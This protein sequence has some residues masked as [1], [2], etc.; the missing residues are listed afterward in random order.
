MNWVLDGITVLLIMIFAATSFNRG[1]LNSVV[2][3]LGTL[4][5]ISASV[6]VSQPAAEFIFDN[7]LY[8][9]INSVVTKHMG[10]ISEFDIAAFTDGMSDLIKELP[11]FFSK[12][13]E[14]GFGVHSEEWY[15]M[16]IAQHADDMTAAVVDN[17]IAPLATGLIRVIVFFA[18]FSLIMLLVNAVAALLIGAN[19]I[20]IIGSLNEVLGGVLGAVHGMLYVFVIASIVWLALSASGG[21]LGPLT[22]EV[23]EKTL[24]FQDFYSIG[25]WVETTAGLL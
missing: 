14:S 13:I 16:I 1:F 6:I 25:P 20:P 7:Y 2:R 3:L 24:I 4:A 22:T 9:G 19:K 23:V 10:E 11:N 5:A 18:V 12:I 17:I 8:K 21:E 15:Q